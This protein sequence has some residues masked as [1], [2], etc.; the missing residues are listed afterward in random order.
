[1]SIE[2][3]NQVLEKPDLPDELLADFLRAAYGLQ[4]SGLTFL[5]LGADVNTVV[6]RVAGE[7]GTPY[8]VKLRRGNLDIP[9][10]LVPRLLNERGIEQ[11]IAPIPTSAGE[12]WTVVEAFT[13][14]VYLF[15]A[16]ENGFDQ[17]LTDA[18]W[19]GLGAALRHIHA[20]DLPSSLA[21]QLPQETFTSYWRERVR[22]YQMRAEHESFT[23]PAANRLTVLIREHRDTISRLV[24]RA[25]ELAEGLQDRSVDLVL[26]HGDIHAGN[27]LIDRNG[28][29]Y[30]VDWDTLSLAPKERD[31]MY[32]GAGIGE[33]WNTVRE[34]D[35]FYRGYGDCQVDAAM[36]AYYRY[37]RVVQDI[38]EFCN[39]LLDSDAGDEDRWQALRYFSGQFTPNDVIDIA[40]RSD[41]ARL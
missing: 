17:P 24:D 41:P 36:I 8:F 29:L 15:V 30:I 7:D 21:E 37:E 10:I 12:L 35:L 4:A 9:S 39:Q 6:Y 13:V 2:G 38:A 32:V 23:D 11:V 26:C 14:V 34:E 5:P 40:F 28:T 18:Q 16:G 25:G 22:A 33:V 31:L 20:T 3:N 27:V 1:M 19:I